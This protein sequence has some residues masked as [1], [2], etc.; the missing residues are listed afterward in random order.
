MNYSNLKD[1][2]LGLFDADKLQVEGEWGF[3]NESNKE[4]KQ[5]GYATNLSPQAIQLAAEKNVDFLLTHHDSWPF[6]FGMKDAC[7][8]LLK[9]TG[10]THAFFHAPL[11]D[12][13][14]GT[15]ASL[16]KALNLQNTYKSIPAQSIF[17]FGRIGETASPI[18]FEEL[19]TLLETRLEEPVRAFQN[20]ARPISKIGVVTGGGNLTTEMKVAVEEGCDTYITGEY[21]L[22]SQQYAK[23]AGINLLV[24][25]HTNTEIWGVQSMAKELSRDTDLKICRIPE[26]NY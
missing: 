9:H 2:L 24:G 20:H 18:T 16:A 3:F 17:F 5:L 10:M 6:V 11:D 14:F 22:Y 15:N 12:A 7:N 13:D 19:Q 23:F 25:S 1:K 26:E 8:T 4:V 21:S